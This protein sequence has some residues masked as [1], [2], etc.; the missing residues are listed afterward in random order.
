MPDNSVWNWIVRK[1]VRA[2]SGS[3]IGLSD[4]SSADFAIPGLNTEDGQSATL[5]SSPAF[6]R[7]RHFFERN[8]PDSARLSHAA[9]S[10]GQRV[11]GMAISDDVSYFSR[12]F[13]KFTEIIAAGLATAVSGYLLAHFSGLSAPAPA[14][15]PTVNQIAPISGTLS[16]SPPTE[17]HS[18]VSADRHEQ[19][20]APQDDGNPSRVRQPAPTL[21]DIK[22]A[23]PARK[24]NA[25]TAVQAP[26]QESLTARVRA[27]LTNVDATRREPVDL[28]P[29]RDD[30][31]RPTTAVALPRPTAESARATA[32]NPEPHSGPT[33]AAPIEPSPVVAVEVK[34]PAIADTQSLPAPST[35]KDTGMLSTLEQ[36]LRHD[37]LA[38]RDEPPRPPLPVGQ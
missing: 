17:P 25:T 10:L 30:T 26:R 33:Q 15:V 32:N 31:A 38:A 5:S 4:G 21:L 22:K 13:A 14:P 3:A 34:S 36:M 29:R 37:P 1:A 7:Y 35:E 6:P 2:Q 23:E 19:H 8:S 11:Y 20:L 9:L 18:A 16:A 24:Q 12:F 27:A 28:P